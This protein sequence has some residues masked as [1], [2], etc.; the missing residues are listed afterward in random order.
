MFKI[1]SWNFIYDLVSELESCKQLAGI[2]DALG[3]VDCRYLLTGRD[4][5]IVTFI[6]PICLISHP[7]KRGYLRVEIIPPA[8]VRS[9]TIS[10]R[11]APVSIQ[12]TRPTS[13]FHPFVTIFL[14][15]AVCQPSVKPPAALFH[16]RGFSSRVSVTVKPN[17]HC[18]PMLKHRVCGLI[19]VFHKHVV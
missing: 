8:I 4:Q 3:D 11:H 7:A 18:S 12:G 1:A 13:P 6:L 16:H 10:S 9:V 2:L 14:P 5:R 17:V 15:H 19:S